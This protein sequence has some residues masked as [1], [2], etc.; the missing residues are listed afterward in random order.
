M[1][2]ELTLG[3]RGLSRAQRD[4]W[5]E[6]INTEWVLEPGGSRARWGGGVEIKTDTEIE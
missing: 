3:G 2:H 4:G 5:D 1:R 6:V